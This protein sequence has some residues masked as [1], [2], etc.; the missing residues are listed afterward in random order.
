[1][2]HGS[3]CGMVHQPV[4]R[5]FFL[6]I[7]TTLYYLAYRKVQVPRENFVHVVSANMRTAIR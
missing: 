5:R 1:M 6:V 4:D 2:P 3:Q 7:V